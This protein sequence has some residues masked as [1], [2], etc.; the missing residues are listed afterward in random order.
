MGRRALG[1]ISRVGVALTQPI[2]PCDLSEHMKEVLDVLGL[3]RENL[4]ALAVGSVK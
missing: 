1:Y 4:P 3:R 2:T